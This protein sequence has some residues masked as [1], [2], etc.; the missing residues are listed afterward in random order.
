MNHL[1]KASLRKEKKRKDTEAE[2]ERI[3]KERRKKVIDE[4]KREQQDE[5]SMA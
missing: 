1:Q 5:I 3:V 4:K 2:I